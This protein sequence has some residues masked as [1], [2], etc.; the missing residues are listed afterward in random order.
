MTVSVARCAGHRAE[1]PTG[2]PMGW[3]ARHPRVSVR[4][5]PPTGEEPPARR[6]RVGLTAEQNPVDRSSRAGSGAFQVAPFK[7][8]D[9]LLH[10]RRLKHIS[11]MRPQPAMTTFRAHGVGRVAAR[12]SP[13]MA[14]LAETLE[15]YFDRLWPINRSIAGP[16][17][18]ASLDVLA[19]LIPTSAT[20]LRPAPGCSIGR[21]PGSGGVARPTSLIPKD[22][23]EPTLPSTTCIWSRIRSRCAPAC[24][25]PNYHHTCTRSP[26]SRIGIPYVL[27]L[28]AKNWGFCLPDRELRALPDGE[29]EVVIDSEL[30]PGRVEIGEAV[31]PGESEDEVLFSSYL[32]HPSLANNELSGPLAIA[33]LYDRLR[34][35]S[36][37]RLT[38]RFLLG[39]ETIGTLCFLSLRGSHLRE[40]AGRLCGDLCRRSRAVHAEDIPSGRLAG[41]PCGA[42]GAAGDGRALGDPV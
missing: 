20:A 26:T 28:Y 14:A 29:Y 1:S 41:R 22:G 10:E 13:P 21:F 25:W 36:T 3:A 7:G 17:L 37:R 23:G 39:A 18:R 42:A 40:T 19:D 16:G 8:L 31:L 33:A 12:V 6:R 32:C 5:T 35:R 30:R 15:E 24:R 9:R 2:R 27:S 4:G 11:V 34:R 38:Y